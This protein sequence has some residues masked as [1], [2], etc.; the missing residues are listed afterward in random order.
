MTLRLIHTADWQLGRAFGNFS[1]GLA[2]R[3]RAARLD[4]IDRI[5][6]HARASGARHV[7]V[8]GDVWDQETPSEA[9]LVQPLERLRRA[10]DL[11]WWLLPGN[12]DPARRQGLWDRLA[13]TGLPANVRVCNAPKPLELEAG[14]WLLPAP[15]TTKRP[16]S[17]PSAVL[18]A[19]PTPAGTLRVGLAHGPVANFAQDSDGGTIALDRAQKAGL[20]YLALGDWHGCQEVAPRTWYAGTPEPDRFPRNEPGFCLAV[21]LEGPG[22][23]PMVQRRPTAAF[24]WRRTRLDWLPGTDTDQLAASA[25]DAALPADHVLLQL[26]LAGTIRLTERLE[27]QAHCRRLGDRLAYLE[28]DD[29]ALQTVVEA[30]DLEALGAESGLRAAADVLASRAIDDPAARRALDLLFTWALEP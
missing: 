5:A 17:D 28:I 3:L 10:A 23:A 6:G 9:T 27:L 18:D 4:A 25:N 26:E 30:G 15:L 12:H 16:A 7:L 21:T 24:R 20:A 22:S 29:T 13:E 19:M 2:A 14:S 1:D 8:A 11:V